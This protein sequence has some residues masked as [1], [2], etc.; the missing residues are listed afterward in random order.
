MNPTVGRIVHYRL[1][2]GPS[3]GQVRPAI[4]VRTW[5]NDYCVQL[6]VFLDE[7]NDHD[8]SAFVSSAIRADSD[9]GKGMTDGLGCWFWPPRE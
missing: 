6:K 4:V 3:A 8:T 1:P 5:D 7:V 2:L 9:A